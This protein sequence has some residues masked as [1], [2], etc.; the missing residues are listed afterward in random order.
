MN[1]GRGKEDLR[2]GLTNSKEAIEFSCSLKASRSCWLVIC[3][4]SV[5]L[6]WILKWKWIRFVFQQVSFMGNSK[7]EVTCGTVNCK[8]ERERERERERGCLQINQHKSFS[9]CS[10]RIWQVV[11]EEALSTN[12]KEHDAVDQKWYK[13]KKKDAVLKSL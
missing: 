11:C 13:E 5:P 12:H 2:V 6:F 1:R 10:A 4:P 3:R 8:V 7:G 9:A